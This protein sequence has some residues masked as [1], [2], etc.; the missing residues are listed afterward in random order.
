MILVTA[1]QM[2]RMDHKTINSFGIPGM[3]LM[4]NA[5]RGAVDIF[6]KKFDTPGKQKLNK[7]KIGIF[8]GRGNNGG[9]GFVIGRYLME[10]GIMTTIFLL[11]TRDKLTGDAKTNML[12]AQK[13]I[14]KTPGAQI[15]EI[16]DT[17]SLNLHKDRIL[18]HDLFIDAIFGTGLHSD[19]KG[20]YKEIIELLNRSRQPIFSIDIPSGLNSDT[21]K[22]QGVAIKATAT[23][24]FAFAKAGHILH[25]GN[26]H[27]GNLEIIDIGIPKFIVKEEDP[28]LFLMENRDITP[29]FAPRNF[30]SHKGKFGHLLVIAGSPGKTGAAALCANAAMR[31]GA[32]LVTL[33]IPRSLNPILESQVTEPMTLPLAQTPE[34]YLSDKNLDSILT[35][36]KDKQALALGPGLGTKKTTRTLVK[37]LVQKTQVPLII[38]ADGLNCIAGH[39]ELLKDRKAPTILTPHP[40]EMARLTGKTT[41]Q[42]QADRIGI[43]RK[44]SQLYQIILV[45]KGAQTLVC[46]PD[47]KTFICPTGNPGMASG[48]MGDVLTGMIAGFITQGIPIEK[49]TMAGVFI[50]GLCGDFLAK[51]TPFGFLASDMIPAIPETIHKLIK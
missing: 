28:K 22:I 31:S 10:K 41:T 15:I 5:G 48:G 45:L 50:H 23:A 42:I 40:G 26:L 13:L 9:D 11:S 24:T 19:V 43:A 34:G 1:D 32:G 46:C 14:K 2:Q 35:L 38:D 20:F 47:G 37:K 4:E 44:F 17:K 12:L 7:Q 27:T 8:A 33:G 30:D 18:L 21:G 16:Q 29:L 3:V 36:L 6:I 49:A 51:K 25:P 39:L